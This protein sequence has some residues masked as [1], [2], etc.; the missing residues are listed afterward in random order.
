MIGKPIHR[1]RA[2]VADELPAPTWKQ[3]AQLPAILLFQAVFIG[4]TYRTLPITLVG[5][6]C[7]G[8]LVAIALQSTGLFSSSRRGN[9]SKVSDAAS[10][11]GQQVGR[12]RGIKS[13]LER[14]RWIV[15]FTAWPVALS[16]GVGAA[17]LRASFHLS[18]NVNPI[19]LI[20]DVTS[21]FSF[22]L[23]L[24]LWIF[25]P[26]RGHPAM[27]PFGL[28][29]VLATITAG[30]VSHTINGQL[31]AA[32]ATVVAFLVASS[33]I[34]P[35]WQDQHSRRARRSQRRNRKKATSR[36]RL[37]AIADSDLIVHSDSKAKLP[38]STVSIT[39]SPARTPALYSIVAISLLLMST[40]AAGHVAARVV[41][42]LQFKF[43]D[44]LSRSLEAV[45]SN[46]PFGG[47]RYVSGSKLG[48]IRNHM[49]GDPGEVA[50]R[51]VADSPPGYLRGT[52]FDTYERG[53]WSTAIERA[54]YSEEIESF[55]PRL[56]NLT[57]QATTE[58]ERTPTGPMS[59]FQV[60]KNPGERFVGT[61]EVHN[62]RL[63][64]SVVFTALSTD[65]AEAV[66]E[67]ITLSHHDMILT[68]LDTQN[69]YVLGITEDTP[70]ESLD[71]IRRSAMLWVPLA[72]RQ[73]IEPMSRSICEDALTPSLKAK[74]IEEFFRDNFQYSLQS[75]PQPSDADPV[76]NFLVT[77]H[78]AHCEYFGT[79]AALMLR[80]VE[81]PTR[82]VTG[83]VVDEI[84]EDNDNYFI[85][86][87][88][89][90]HAWV[91]A[92]DETTERWFPVE[93]TLGRTYRTLTADET[94]T[95]DSDESKETLL[96]F[97]DEDSFFS[98][99]FGLIFSFRASDSLQVVFRFA[100][101][102][103]FCVALVLLWLRYRGRFKSPVDGDD[104]L[105]GQ[106]LQR[107]DRL[108]K[109]H[110]LIRPETETLHQFA[111]RVEFAAASETESSR[112][113]F[114]K[115]A[116]DWYRSFAA[117]RYQGKLPAPIE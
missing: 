13:W 16:A 33:H 54:F 97:E 91:E 38:A 32:L 65:W 28:I 34:L 3:F 109:R 72:I 8:L 7:A 22:F 106:M 66:G 113:E 83:Y 114:L 84:D 56:A 110:T 94:V 20:V 80:C 61:V 55:K 117:A 59:R 48:T 98:R 5:L 107:A 67:Q 88:R 29:I 18:G 19:A 17:V 50:L 57:G 79:A 81:V 64:G 4:S 26:R 58:L 47:T 31:V 30:G 105:S 41:P 96:G 95:D 36:N 12:E 87:N 11:S 1:R 15:H 35:Y 42:G 62:R 108:L 104:Q 39:D 63:K 25:F 103:L 111:S 100:Q 90:A 116:A 89:D 85:A 70:Q 37:Q 68:G 2:V 102:P 24:V 112:A 46:S 43:F 86:R 92:Y 101:L 14:N 76:S 40:S 53:E 74:A 10:S 52:V 21:H 71:E 82:Y 78:P 49:I 9:R 99:V 27:L 75:Q 93:A 44:R 115:R 73:V 45:T 51:A 69:P 23:T 6:L 77:R 60:R